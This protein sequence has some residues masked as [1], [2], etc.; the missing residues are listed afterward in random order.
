[1]EITIVLR[2]CA[3]AI[4]IIGEIAYLSDRNV[5]KSTYGVSRNMKM[6]EPMTLNK[7]LTAAARLAE[8]LPPMDANTA[9]TVVPILE[10]KTNGSRCV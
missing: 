7:T 2:M 4:C 5:I 8:V 3:I 6:T 1:M 10:P 9:V